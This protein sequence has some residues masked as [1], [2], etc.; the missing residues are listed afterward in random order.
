MPHS[1]SHTV[2]YSFSAASTRHSNVATSNSTAAYSPPFSTCNLLLYMCLLNPLIC[3]YNL[4]LTVKY[5]VLYVFSHSAL[6][7]IHRPQ[8]TVDLERQTEK[9]AVNGNDDDAGD[10]KKTVLIALLRHLSVRHLQNIR[11]R[12]VTDADDAEDEGERD[13]NDYY[14]ADEESDTG[15]DSSASSG[16]T[17]DDMAYLRPPEPAYRGQL[18]PPPVRTALVP[19]TIPPRQPGRDAVQL[20]FSFPRLVVTHILSPLA[21]I[22]LLFAGYAA[23]L[24]CIYSV[25][26]GEPISEHDTAYLWRAWSRWVC[27]PVH[28]AHI[29]VV[30]VK[31]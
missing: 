12:I 2:S 5:T 11:V 1:P 3:V 24:G 7:A 22:A 15:R 21:S 26:L 31:K 13:D 27:W 29:K 6:R 14:D 18:L 8:S 25:C 23:A 10:S 28:R 9:P 20:E 17:N 16:V 19:L 4:Y 30:P